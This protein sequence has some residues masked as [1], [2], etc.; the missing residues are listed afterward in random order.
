M[1]K[2]VDGKYTLD[3]EKSLGSGA[4]STVYLAYRKSNP[5]EK[6]ACK[7]ISK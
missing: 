5:D 4:Y 7:V 1:K 2:T 6:Y 3:L